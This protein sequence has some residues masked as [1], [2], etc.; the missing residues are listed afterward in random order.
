M[1]QLSAHGGLT[2]ANRLPLFAPWYLGQ[3]CDMNLEDLTCLFKVSVARGAGKAIAENG[4]LACRLT[5]AQAYSLYDRTVIDRWI[6]DELLVPCPTGTGI[7]YKTLFD[8]KTLETYA[9][10][11]NSIPCLQVADR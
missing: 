8:N 2:G 10:S 3:V 9:A 5:K 4:T 11:S 7:T 1:Q 6:L